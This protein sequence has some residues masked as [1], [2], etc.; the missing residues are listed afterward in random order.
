MNLRG[1][2]LRR[3]AVLVVAVLATLAA[4]SETGQAAARMNVQLAPLI[5]TGINQVQQ[6]SFGGKIGFR[7]TV[8]NSGDS[9]ANHLVIVVESDTATYA[10]SSSRAC[11]ADLSGK[12]M[13]CTLTQMKPGS[14]PFSVDLRFV[15]PQSGTTV[16]TTPSVTVDAQTRG[17]PGNNGTQTTT[18]A[19]VKTALVSSGGDS[20][21]KTY[22]KG[23]ETV[24]TSGSLPQHS[25]FQMPDTLLGDPYGVELSVQET[26]GTPL[27]KKCP[28]FVTDLQIPSSTVFSSTNAYSFAIT[29]LPAG[30]PPGYQPSGLYHDGIVVPMCSS[31]PLGGN[32]HMCLTSFVADKTGVVA[33]GIADQNGKIGFG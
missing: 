23:K 14:P 4:G 22:A 6:V 3:V 5:G 15:A 33:R 17:Q 13:V 27:C 10:D 24:A 2:Q 30:E 12:R 11:T 19:A 8:S 7:L 16:V 1:K 9:T 25:S 18:G 28:P 29:L 26:T 31:Q 32:T 21:I 20:L